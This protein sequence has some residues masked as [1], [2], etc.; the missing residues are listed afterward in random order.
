MVVVERERERED[1]IAI[2]KQSQQHAPLQA[3]QSQF[4]FEYTLI[5]FLHRL[6]HLLAW[7]TELDTT[8]TVVQLQRTHM[9]L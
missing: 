7:C 2:A 5:G 9:T 6:D 3:I 4:Q 1:Y 8:S